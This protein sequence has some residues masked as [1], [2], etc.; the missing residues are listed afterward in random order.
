MISV[1]MP[2]GRHAFCDSTRP[3]Q[4]PPTARCLQSNASMNVVLSPVSLIVAGA[5]GRNA[6]SESINDIRSGLIC[7]VSVVMAALRRVDASV[8]GE[9]GTGGPRMGGKL[10]NGNIG[11]HDCSS[12]MGGVPV[13]L[14]RR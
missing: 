6:S 2:N 11:H 1:T 12:R 14:R 13:P 3:E 7:S 10:S 4:L 5:K 8:P 9:I